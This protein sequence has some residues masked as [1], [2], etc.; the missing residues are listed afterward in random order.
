M[1]LIPE[2]EI[3]M[4]QLQGHFVKYRASLRGAIKNV[5]EVLHANV[6]N[7]RHSQ[8][9]FQVLC[10]VG[11]QALLPCFEWC[12]VMHPDDCARVELDTLKQRCPQLVYH[13]RQVE[14]LKRF[15]KGFDDPEFM[16]TYRDRADQALVKRLFLDA[17]AHL[18]CDSDAGAADP[19]AA[20]GPSPRASPGLLLEDLGTGATTGD[21]SS[22]S[23]GG[24]S[25]TATTTTS[26]VRCR[27]MSR[28]DVESLAKELVDKLSDKHGKISLSQWQVRRLLALFPHQP[29][30]V[31]ANVEAVAPQHWSPSLAMA[32]LSTFDWLKRCG[33]QAFVHAVEVQGGIKTFEGFVN[34]GFKDADA[35]SAKCGSKLPKDKAQL[36]L[37]MSGEV[38]ACCVLRCVVC[39]GVKSVLAAHD[40]ALP[41]AGV[42]VSCLRT[43]GR[44]RGRATLSALMASLCVCVCVCVRVSVYVR[45]LPR[46]SASSRGMG[47][48]LALL[49]RHRHN[50][51][52]H[53]HKLTLTHSL[54]HSRTHTTRHTHLPPHTGQG[55]ARDLRAHFARP[56]RGF[57]AGAHQVLRWQRH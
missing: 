46:P 45:V 49:T 38:S 28:V 56:R 14:R 6:S 23:S 18:C 16:K 20:A 41:A 10:G 43:P 24:G 47:V 39:C 51:H 4:A 29:G 33:M 12:G 57:P 55:R 5:Q 15:L 52:T 36:L 8:T 54:T 32:P 3:S 50:A 37:A 48:G 7:K 53:I 2:Q 19:T 25:S 44:H 9:L 13:P 26:S 17:Y 40:A 1:Q 31:A 22:R 21:S 42:T 27:P 30:R 34:A 11:L 35:L